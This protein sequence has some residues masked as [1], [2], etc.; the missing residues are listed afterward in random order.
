MDATLHKHL[1]FLL[2]FLALGGIALA[3]A[4]GYLVAR[5]A[6]VPVDRLTASAER[7]AATMDL[8]EQ[9]EVQGVDEIARL[10]QALNALLSAVDQSQQAQRRLV[11]GASHELRTPLTSVRTNLELLARSPGILEEERRA[12]LADL[13]AQAAELSTL[14]GQLVDLEREPLTTEQT[15]QVRLDQIAEEARSPAPACTARR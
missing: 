9:I 14:V 8:S 12:I 6:L 2:T 11:A 1:V 7:V 3:V 13:V 15:G 5:A 10:G 4:L